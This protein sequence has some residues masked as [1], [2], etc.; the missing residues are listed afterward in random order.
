MKKIVAYAL[1]A[2]TGILLCFLYSWTT[3][4]SK[5]DYVTLPKDYNIT[6]GLGTIK[7]GT[8]LKI[9]AVV[10]DGFTRYILYL[11]IKDSEPIQVDSVKG[12]FNI[13]PYWLEPAV[14]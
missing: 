9:D 4:N 14:E 2:V 8:K 3:K 6:N 11:N 13:K 10:G 7:K 1:G 5:Y 12:K